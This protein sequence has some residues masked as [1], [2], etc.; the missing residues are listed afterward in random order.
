MATNVSVIRIKP[1]FYI[2]VLDNNSNVTRVEIG[3]NTFTRQEHE[4]VVFGPEEMIKIPPRH[5]VIVSNPVRRDDKN[6]P[7]LDEFGNAML[8]FGDEEV[9][10]EKTIGEPFPLY[11]G[12]VL[13]GK[14]SPLPFVAANSAIRLR[15]I[16]NCVDSTGK[17]RLAGDEWIFEG[18][19]TYYPQPEVQVV[20]N[21]VATIIKE[22]EAIRLRARR[23]TTDKSGKARLAG[24][25]WLVR[26]S[27]AYLPGAD[28][29]IVVTNG[30]SIVKAIVLTDKKALHL[31]ST[32][33][34]TD[35]Y[36]KQR[37][38]GEEWLVTLQDSSTH[39]PDVYEEVV[40]EVKIT[41]L[42]NR[43]YC[44][45]LDPVSPDEEGTNQLGKKE[46]RV[47]EA[48]FFLRP[49]ERLDKGIQNIYVLSEEEALLLYALQEFKDPSAKD[50]KRKAGD[51]WM[52]FG[53]ADYIPP[54]E[55]EILEKRKRIP[56]DRNEGIYVRDNKTGKIRLEFGQSYMLQPHEELW[57]KILPPVVEDLLSKAG[58]ERLVGGASKASQ[59]DK[60]RMVTYR[61][62]H[63][64]AVQV[65]DFKAKESRVVFGPG[66]VMLGPDEEFTVLSLSGGTPKKQDQIK[67]LCLLLGPDFMTDVVIVET[68]DHA[69]LA[70]QLAYNWHFEVTTDAKNA[71]KIF[72]VPDFVG[73][74]CKAIAS[75]VR[76]SVASCTFDHFHRNSADII[77]AAVFGI[78][79]ETKEPRTRLTFLTN[80][81]VIT[82]IDIQSV[83]PVDERTRDSLQ[84]SVQLAIEITTNSQEA[85]ARHEAQRIEQAA[86]G[87]L[88]IQKINNEIEAEKERT[89]LL[90]LQAQSANVEAT[91][92][93]IAEAK[94]RTDALEIEA[95][96]S[97]KQAEL[98]A[99][100]ARIKAKADLEQAKARNQSEVKHLEALNALEIAKAKELSSI[101]TRK[102]S[103]VVNALGA[104]TIQAMAQAGPE[105]QAKLL[106]GL[107]LKSF[108]ITDGNS[109]I[110]LFNTANGLIGGG[111]GSV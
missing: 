35:V 92:Q 27:G 2:H 10:F 31:R 45:V 64:S 56:L 65:Y 81:L 79:A 103:N 83:E 77:R 44:V 111:L 49:G 11:P 68:S 91:G 38:A 14:I 48:S 57:E 61:A 80:N 39:I 98:K 30:I 110:N 86:N 62:P 74:A 96:A 40:G 42:S 97:V 78:D 71:A 3:P 73:D 24:E 22:N 99:E 19:N 46:L 17:N 25:E 109:P 87:Q 59:R 108:M 89:E 72:Q 29:E 102:F 51:K 82:N 52:I 50:G 100:A 66:L 28:E 105:L 43:Q 106:Q 104:D 16:R 75:R 55:V 107:G 70:L 36:R 9:L 85:S 84:K 58:Q 26:E 53:P 8:R 20:E 76:G 95:K 33:T 60:T 54:I 7:I 34:F 47:G 13:V 23:K 90:K 88:E 101:E 37:K 21:I 41:T 1:Y 4:K 94:A 32:K 67:T 18:P 5:Y 69:R 12:E 6:V 93:A 15:A 63:N